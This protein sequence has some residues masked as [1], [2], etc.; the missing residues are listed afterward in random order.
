MEFH[1]IC[2]I[3]PKMND[4]EFLDLIQDI[5]VN[6]Q[7]ESIKTYQG[8]IIDGRNRFLACQRLNVEPVFSEW[9]GRGSLVSY[10][11]SL[12]LIRRHLTASQG[13]VVANKILPFKEEEA[14]ERQKTLAGTRPNTDIDLSQKI[15]EGIIKGRA[16]EQVAQMFGTN[17]QYVT[18]V[19]KISENAKELIPFIEDGTLTVPEAK[20][21]SRD[22]E[23]ERRQ[24]V[25]Q[26]FKDIDS[27]GKKPK[28]LELVGGEKKE[29]KVEK[30]D[31]RDPEIKEY[32]EY[33]DKCDKIADEFRE[34]IYQFVLLDVD[35]GNL[36][37][38]SQF[39]D[40]KDVIQAN[41]DNMEIILSKVLKIK[42]F[43]RGLK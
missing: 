17:R 41:I 11:L 39:L 27:G 29:K 35:D 32:D 23:P 25:I 36:N 10:V 13:A 7:I 26:K 33:I 3:F 16:T 2:E 20:I 12:N 18:D 37:A 28:V 40:A 21:I 15:D 42:K 19:K 6:G 4:Q 5:A 9:D 1:P 38:W 30:V 34:V 8:K 22:V 43:L 14:R 24:E 31:P